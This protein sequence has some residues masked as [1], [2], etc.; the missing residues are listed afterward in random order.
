MIALAWGF[1][2]VFFLSALIYGVGL[3]LVW[4]SC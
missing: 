4:K 1:Q 3:F 2:A